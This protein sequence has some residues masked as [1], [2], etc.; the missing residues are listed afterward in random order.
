MRSNLVENTGRGKHAGQ[1][2][3]GMRSRP[4]EKK[5][6]DV[7]AR[8][9]GAEP[10]ALRQGGLEPEAGAAVSVELLLKIEGRRNPRSHDVPR[11]VRKNRC[12]E[13]LLNRRAVAFGLDLPVLSTLQIG[14][15]R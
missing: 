14:D 3:A 5:I 15:R 2:S 1:S 9:M 12:L 7:L 8:I 6:A 10:G 11:K 4:H 13:R